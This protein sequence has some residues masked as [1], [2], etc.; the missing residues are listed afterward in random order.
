MSAAP[1]LHL[2]GRATIDGM[3]IFGPVSVEAPAG[4]WTCLLGPSGVGK[5]TVLRLLAG[6]GDELAFEGEV[7]A[8]DGSSLDN[9]VALMAQSDLLMPWLDVTANVTLGARLRGDA[10]PR[11]RARDVLERVGLAAHSAK[12]PHALSGGQRQRAALARTLM[13]DRPVV[14]LD[15]PFSALDARSRAL[16]QDLAAELLAGRTVLHVTHD[17]A[18]AARLGHHVLL[19]TREGIASVTPPAGPT[20][21]VYDAPETLAFQGRLLRLLME[22]R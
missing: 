11:D 14:L 2:S 10:P 6:V 4:E 17:A 15:E 12:R 1:A 18:E 19:M 7:A 21:R 8:G 5:S 16:M 13:E 9:R 22:A 20:P 3:P